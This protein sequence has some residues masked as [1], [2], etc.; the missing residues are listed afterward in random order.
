MASKPPPP[1]ARTQ[2]LAPTS[3]ISVLG[4]DLLC[5]TFLRLPSL[6]S[7]VRAALTCRNFLAAIRGSPVFRRRFREIHRPSL[8]GFFFDPDGPDIPWFAPVRRQSD[9]DLTAAIRRADFFLTGIPD[10]EDAYPGWQIQDCRGGYLLLVNWDTEQIAA[11][12]PLTLALDLIPLPPNEIAD[13]CNGELIYHG[14]HLVSSGEAPGTFRVIFSC[15]D[16]SRVRVAVFSSGARHWRMLPWGEVP[17][18]A[19]PAEDQYWLLVG[20]QANGCLYWAHADEAYQLVLD[21]STL[22]FS[23]IVL[24]GLLEGQGNIYMTGET[25]DGSP[26]I[27][28]ALQF[29]LCVYCQKTGDDGVR[30]WVLHSR[31]WLLGEV[32]EATECSR[33]NLVGLKVWAIMDGIVYMSTSESSRDPGAAC[34]F[35]S[36]CL[37]TRKLEKVF[38]RVHDSNVYPYI[39]PWPLFLLKQ[40]IGHEV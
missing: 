25:K 34:W 7:L 15:H 5:E 24:P 40:G 37:E 26:C 12:N 23:S 6:P 14:F 35:L 2:S 1:A 36:F 27:V 19:L 30:K 18:P 21:T 16:A 20:A 28:C 10:C 32:L 17:M 29:M 38:H 4:H 13:G 9:R 11:Y 39:M 33:D 31:I 22:Q 8:L 3:T